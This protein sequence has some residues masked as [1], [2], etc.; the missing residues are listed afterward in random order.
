MSRAPLHPLAFALALALA[1]FFYPA[2]PSAA[3]A[4][5]D[6]T[7]AGWQQRL[8]AQLPLQLE[9]ADESGRVAPLSHYFGH[10]P[11]AIVLMYLDCTQL[12]PLTMAQIRLAFDRSGLT[13]GRDFTLLAVS[14]DPWD[15][16]AQAATRKAA[17]VHDAA[18]G[19]GL[20]ILTAP[21]GSAPDAAPGG[22]LAGAAGF[23]YIYDPASRQYGHP[24]GWLLADAHGRIEHYFFGVRF[25]PVGVARAVRQAAAG[26]QPT[27]SE[28]L[29]LLCW[30]LQTLTGRFDARIYD[31]LR[32]VCLTLLAA[33]GALLWR[34]ARRP[35]RS[36]CGDDR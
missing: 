3:Q 28:P 18:W 20:H 22:R 6:L 33:G 11:V 9:F 2:R 32:L 35:A 25:D 7:R 1:L 4:P 21:P 27:W 10:H 16:A 34:S 23:G 5:P 36:P 15:R 8:G 26:G 19:R 12:C 13:P 24:A 17:L 14:I 30:C 29:R 31:I